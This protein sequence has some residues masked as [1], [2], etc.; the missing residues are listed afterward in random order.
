MEGLILIRKD[1]MSLT[2]PII[3]EQA[4]IMLMGVVNT[5]MAG[6]LGKEAVSAVGMVDSINNI[7]ISFFSA[8]AVGGTVVIAH[9]MGQR[10]LKQINETARHALFSGAAVSLTA[11]LFIFIF[12]TPIIS[13][14]FG[15]AEKQV[16]SNSITY[17]NITLLTYPLIALTSISFGIL[18]GVGD[19]RTPMK[20][21]ITMNVLNVVL[22]YLMIYGLEING[23]HFRIAIPKL[24]ILGAAL[25]IA[26]ARIIGAGLVL[27]AVLSGA[28]SVKVRISRDFK[29]DFSLL[30]SI[31]GIGVPASVESLLFNV[32]KLI[33]QVFIVGMG[34]ASIAANYIAGSIFGML[35][36]PGGALGIAATT[37]V[38]QH[39]G[40]KESDEAKS[41]LLYLV[42]L[43]SLSSLIM[44]AIAFPFSEQLARMYTQSEDV[45]HLTSGLIKSFS[46]SMPTLWAISFLIPAGLKGAGD[47]KYTMSVSII[48][49]WLFR[50]TLG[51]ILGVPLKMGVLGVWLG[52]YADWLV[53]GVLF[54]IRLNRGKWKD[55]VVV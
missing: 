21:T 55:N 48:G 13:L 9:Y 35:N 14:L 3:A 53:R 18:R 5:I 40:R 16:V 52:M 43:A 23:A 30:K 34:T 25:G 54:Y 15:N 37:L 51:Y 50:V 20:V 36:I 19:T 2:L 31:F 24:G 7:F 10:N 22:T 4:F 41:T 45:V 6:H 11:T 8:L 33:T 38:G 26:G 42:K 27:Y 17:L 47:A 39:M 1:V 49:M 46:I 29:A 12:Q 28:K 44:C 32:G